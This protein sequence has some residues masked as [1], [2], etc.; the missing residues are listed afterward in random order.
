M[1]A[2]HPVKVRNSRIGIEGAR[3]PFSHRESCVQSG[4]LTGRLA[5][6]AAVEAA[7]VKEGVVE[8]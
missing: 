2:V 8:A 1:Q 5:G 4:D 3:R 6:R 7:K